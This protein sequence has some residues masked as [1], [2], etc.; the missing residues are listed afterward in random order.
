MFVFVFMNVKIFLAPVTWQN[1]H[2]YV[3]WQNPELWESIRKALVCLMAGCRLLVAGCRL[4][5]LKD[6]LN[7]ILYGKVQ[8]SPPRESISWGRTYPSPSGWQAFR[9]A[10]L[11]LMIFR[12]EYSRAIKAGM[13]GFGMCLTHVRTLL[14]NA[15]SA[16]AERTLESAWNM[17]RCSRP[18][19]TQM[20]KE[21][22]TFQQAWTHQVAVNLWVWCR[23]KDFIWVAQCV[24]CQ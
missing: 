2:L 19:M 14:S 18:M 24:D 3:L 10:L 9:K 12:N 16:S 20:S 22:L 4:L 11:I 15:H 5:F 21:M 6:F 23:W 7:D 13:H 17:S 1:K 8:T